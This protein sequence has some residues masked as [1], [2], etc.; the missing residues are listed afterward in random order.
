MNKIFVYI[1]SHIIW[2][3]VV[4]LIFWFAGWF[5]SGFPPIGL[6]FLVVFGIYF[7]R[8]F[9]CEMKSG[10]QTQRAGFIHKRFVKFVL[11]LFL[12]FVLTGIA[13]IITLFTL[14]TFVWLDRGVEAADEIVMHNQKL[15]YGQTDLFVALPVV[16]I[17]ILLYLRYLKQKR[18]VGESNISKN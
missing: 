14:W 16:I 18:V 15:A 13:K 10:I 12:F 17:L 7:F 1:D 9:K 4:A 8:G 3:I 2:V 5:L 6:L 11:F